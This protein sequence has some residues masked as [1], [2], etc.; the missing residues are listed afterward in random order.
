MRFLVLA[1]LVA[2]PC[3]AIAEQTDF[4]GQDLPQGWAVKGQVGVD[5]TQNRSGSALKIEPGGMAT[6]TFGSEGQAGSVDLWVYEDMTT[7]K[8]PKTRRVGPRWGLIG[9]GGKAL[10]VG[11]LCAPYLNGKDTYTLSSYEGTTWFNVQYLGECRRKAG[12]HRWTF[13]MDPAKGASIAMDGKDVNAQR[14][15]FDWN[16]TEFTGMVGVAIYGDSGPKPGQTI[17]VDDVTMIVGGAMTAKPTPPPPP[18][19]VVPVSDPAEANP[20]SLVEAVRGKHP[21]LLFGAEDVATLKAFTTHEKGKALFDR[22]LKYVPVCK[23]PTHRNFLKDATDGQRQGFWRMPTVGLHYV[24]TGE[25]PSLDNATGFLKMLLEL[26]HWE[27]GKELDCGM[28]A[29][30]IMVGAALCYDWLYHDLDPAFREDVRKKLLFHARAMYHG[31]H[32]NKV[33]SIGYWQADP[34]NNHRWHRNVGMTLCALAVCEGRPDEQWIL[35]KVSDE[36]AFVAKW[37]PEDGTSHESP[38]YL[39]FGAS[40]LTLAMQASDRCFGTKY[41]DQ[42]FFRNVP[43]FRLHA[44]LPGLKDAFCFGD[45]G[46]FG[47]YNNFTFKCAAQHRLADAQDGLWRL[48]ENV[49]KAFEFTWF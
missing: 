24:L 42:P 22:L 32:L 37:L 44:V 14:K 43:S 17:W 48:Y 26:E 36:L 19:P 28:S 1:L 35:R 3:S 5:A 6:W 11:A 49:P 27:T 29:A 16:K 33:K 7:P 34:A 38:S 25:R 4:N 18:P 10:V 39:A 41:L 40:H 12:W 15:R 47:G 46:G 2:L 20:V 23:A 13:T 9:P 30:N 21:R 31:G 45:G 8:N